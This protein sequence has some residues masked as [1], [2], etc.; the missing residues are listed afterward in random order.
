MSYGIGRI[1]ADVD[2]A[3]ETLANLEAA[4]IM[5]QQASEWERHV[6]RDWQCCEHHRTAD[7]QI[8]RCPERNVNLTIW[9]SGTDGCAVMCEQHW[10]EYHRARMRNPEATIEQIISHYHELANRTYPCAR[11]GRPAH[12]NH[13]AGEA[14]CERH[15][16]AY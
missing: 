10:L 5:A 8:E 11:C 1:P 2:P 13:S 15:W 12:M 14:L 6:L 16:E 3:S 4:E 9:R 7:G